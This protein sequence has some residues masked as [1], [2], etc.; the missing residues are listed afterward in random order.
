[1][2][3]RYRRIAPLGGNVIEIGSSGTIGRLEVLPVADLHVD[4]S[5]QREITPGSAKNILRIAAAFDWAKFLP[6]IVV[7]DGGHY[8]IIDGQH[9]ATAAATIGIE[10]VPCYVLSCSVAKAAAAFAAINSNVTRLDAVDLYFAKLAA[11]VPRARELARVLEA[12][13]VTVTR[14][15]RDYAAGETRA[16]QVLLR[17]MEKY[18]PDLLLVILQCITRTGDR[19][20]GALTGAV[21]NGVGQAI[22]SKPGLL[23]MPSRLF[24]ILDGVSLSD[25][26]ARARIESAETRN[27]AQFI[28][29]REINAILAEAREV[30]A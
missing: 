14:K 11:G 19:N 30:A 3:Q 26:F 2:S 24:E 15:R 1:V 16:V 23:A 4:A 12:A 29:T 10:A 21:I 9:R 5:Y 6:V 13:G 25:L 18:G 17:A 8:A 27:P 20:P 28:I 7:R 22:R